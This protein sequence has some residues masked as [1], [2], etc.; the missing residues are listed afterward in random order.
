MRRAAKLYGK[1][2]HPRVIAE[3]IG[4]AP[5]TVWRYLRV[6]GVPKLQTARRVA[7]V[8][9]LKRSPYWELHTRL[10]AYEV[11][12]GRKY[13]PAC[14]RWRHLCDFPPERRRYGAA[15][16]RCRACRSIGRA[17]YYV[18]NMT[19]AQRADMRER[20][21]IYYNG[22][23]REAGVPELTYVRNSVID[24]R[25]AIYLP[26]APLKAALDE[27]DDGE[28][29]ELARRAGIPERTIYRLRYEGAQVQID[30][31]DKLAVALGTTS[32]LLFGELWEG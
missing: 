17:Y 30:V 9:L 3:R 12:C 5:T 4:V 22:K 18:H 10:G 24:N 6:A 14:G 32:Q 21:R 8:S 20:H 28:F 15:M 1:G 29:G 19:E 23:R 2:Y 26:V 13:C 25:E 7:N 11:V 16:S 31:A 27:L